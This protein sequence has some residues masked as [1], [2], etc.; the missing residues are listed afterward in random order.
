MVQQKQ[1]LLVSMRIQ[2]K[3]PELMWLWHRPAPA[4]L[5]PPLAWELSYA[6]PVALKNKTLKNAV[7]NYFLLSRLITLPLNCFCGP[8]GS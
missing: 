1:T 5:I 4:A 8:G 3:D 6:A 2:T 7:I